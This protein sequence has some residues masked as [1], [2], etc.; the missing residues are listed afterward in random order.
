MVNLLLLQLKGLDLESMGFVVQFPNLTMSL[1]A[2]S[3]MLI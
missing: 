1:V 3:P 2:P